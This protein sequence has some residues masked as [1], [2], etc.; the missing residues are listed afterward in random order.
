M[1]MLVSFVDN[2]KRDTLNVLPLPLFTHAETST[3]SFDRAIALTAQV[4]VGC[5]IR[6]VTKRK[7]SSAYEAD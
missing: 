1:G 2:K 4:D 5:L 7:G 6:R 3:V